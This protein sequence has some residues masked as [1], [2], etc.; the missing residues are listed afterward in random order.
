MSID[1]VLT[2]ASIEVGAIAPIAVHEEVRAFLNLEAE[3][4]DDR[5]FADWLEIVAEDFWYRMPV[6]VTPDNPVAARYDA[7]ALIIDENRQTLMDHWFRR[8]EPDMWEMAWA[9]NPPVRYRH[10]V[11]NIRVRE[12]A[13]P[14]LYQVRSNA[15]VTATRQSDQPS[16][17]YVERFD[18][19][20]RTPTGWQLRERFV[21][22]ESTVIDFAQLRVIL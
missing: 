4:V 13:Q 9:E 15:I 8:Y 16:T 20:R 1:A 18:I 14:E 12:T 10:F 17:L 6:P 5:R 7:A 11:S 22:P 3:M 21:V 2:P 19:L